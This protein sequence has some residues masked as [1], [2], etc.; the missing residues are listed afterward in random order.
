[1]EEKDNTSCY[2]GITVW[3]ICFADIVVS[4]DFL[5]ELIFSLSIA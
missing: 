4:C 5:I 1:M 2:H 3:R